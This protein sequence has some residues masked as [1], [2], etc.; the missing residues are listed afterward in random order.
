MVVEH[1]ADTDSEDD[2]RCCA[3]R[4]II[5]TCTSVG[6]HAASFSLSTYV[7][8]SKISTTYGARVAADMQHCVRESSPVHIGQI[9]VALDGVGSGQRLRS[10]GPAGLSSAAS[11]MVWANCLHTRAGCIFTITG[12]EQSPVSSF[13]IL[14]GRTHSRAFCLPIVLARVGLQQQRVLR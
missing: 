5:I 7:N 4:V 1:E 13:V 10:R 8:T 3:S 12:H 11:A 2:T 6:A 14:G 9:V